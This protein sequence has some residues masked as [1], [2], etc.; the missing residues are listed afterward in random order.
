MSNVTCDHPFSDFEYPRRILTLTALF[1]K[2]PAS[3]LPFHNFA[4]YY[5][6]VLTIK[7]LM[8]SVAGTGLSEVIP[9]TIRVVGGGFVNRAVTLVGP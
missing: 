6:I 5:S 1:T 7:S 9:T 3:R 4:W 2:P 8:P